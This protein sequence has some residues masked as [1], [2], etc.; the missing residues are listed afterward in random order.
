MNKEDKISWILIGILIL[1]TCCLIYFAQ[2]HYDQEQEKIDQEWVRI[3][4]K[5]CKGE[6]IIRRAVDN[7][8]VCNK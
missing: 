1:I 4:E 8:I 6:G 5:T 3:L 2:R 7:Q